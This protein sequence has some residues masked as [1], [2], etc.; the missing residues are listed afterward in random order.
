MF[1]NI[2]AV[3]LKI[4]WHSPLLSAKVKIKR[5]T[6]YVKDLFKFFII[7]LTKDKFMNIRFFQCSFENSLNI[8]TQISKFPGFLGLS[9]TINCGANS[10]EELKV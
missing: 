3:Y 7:L 9:F 2:P 1:I 6:Q 5:L 4:C 8:R 10:L